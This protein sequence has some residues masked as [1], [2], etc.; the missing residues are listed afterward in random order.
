VSIQVLDGYRADGGA[1]ARAV[2]ATLRD[3]GYRVVA[4][5]PALAYDVTTVLYT[6]GNEPAARQVAADLGAGVVRE[7]PANL[8][9][10]VAVH[11]VVGADR[12]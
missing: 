5:N 10:Q 4:E 8:S 9:D 11:V 3:T 7:K 2:A 1:A 6:A 12:G